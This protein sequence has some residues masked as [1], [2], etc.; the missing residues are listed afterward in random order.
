MYNSTQRVHLEHLFLGGA[1]VLGV[2]WGGVIA[3]IRDEEVRN[4]SHVQLRSVS[5]I[6]AGSIAACL[7]ACGL[8]TS[9]MVDFFFSLS[10]SELLDGSGSLTK[11]IFTLFRTGGLCAGLGIM[12]KMDS[13]L[14]K[15]VGVA[16]ATFRQLAEWQGKDMPS[17]RVFATNLNTGG[18]VCFSAETSPNVEVAWAVR[19]S[20]GV[21]LVWCP[22]EYK[23]VAIPRL[24]LRTGDLLTDGVTSTGL[25]EMPLAPPSLFKRKTTVTRLAVGMNTHGR[26]RASAARKDQSLRGVAEYL[27]LLFDTSSNVAALQ[28]LRVE[29]TALVTVRSPIHFLNFALTRK[30]ASKLFA[31]GYD[32]TKWFFRDPERAGVTAYP[33]PQALRTQ[34]KQKPRVIFLWDAA[35]HVPSAHAAHAL[36]LGSQTWLSADMCVGCGLGAITAFLQATHTPLQ[37][38]VFVLLALGE[39]PVRP[40][41]LTS[42]TSSLDETIRWLRCLENLGFGSDHQRK[43]FLESLVEICVGD[44]VAT[45]KDLPNLVLT[46]HNLSTGEPVDFSFFTT[47]ETHLVHALMAATAL[48]IYF[49]PVPE[50]P[51]APKTDL[52]ISSYALGPTA[53]HSGVLRASLGDQA[54]LYIIE[55]T[56]S[57]RISTELIRK[58]VG[59]F[60]HAVLR[61]CLTSGKNSQEILYEHYKSRVK[62]TY[63]VS[64]AVPCWYKGKQTLALNILLLISMMLQLQKTCP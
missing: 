62:K 54:S 8:E 17:L 26:L 14:N 12:Q 40:S 55:T 36:F 5:G 63:R 22:M 25:G 59:N 38:A 11:D 56:T 51:K 47:P 45:F 1:G 43:D 39:S 33:V 57:Q 7:Y 28:R 3:A 21:P 49:A 53:L 48:P 19:A 29:G 13:L 32:R 64:A 35:A 34:L 4:P 58:S 10:P 23:G 16:G 31:L 27:A 50:N 44:K 2:A 30:Q 46:A 52:L 20:V 41:D 24:A 37:R 42:P 18:S 60:A 9:G 15:C 61:T 6:S